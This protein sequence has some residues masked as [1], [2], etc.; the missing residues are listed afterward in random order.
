M[1]AAIPFARRL[2]ATLALAEEWLVRDAK[3]ELRCLHLQ[4]VSAPTGSGKTGVMELT[5][6]RLLSE[7][8]QPQEDRAPGN[9]VGAVET[10][11]S[12][13]PLRGTRKAVY[14][15]PMRALV[16][17]KCKDWQARWVLSSLTCGW[18]RVVVLP[19]IVGNP[20]WR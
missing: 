16:Q 12:L 11:R 7:Y 2:T 19:E 20:A 6:L 14:V 8:L 18:A 13:R 9:D 5:L 4:V 15:A 17:E 10:G 3:M 1:V